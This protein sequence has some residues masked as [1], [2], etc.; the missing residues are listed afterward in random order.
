MNAERL[1]FG[2]VVAAVAIFL[3]V[4]VVTVPHDPSL[5]VVYI[6]Y[7]S[8]KGDNSY[9]DS[10]YRG[11]FAAQE[12]M[13]F[14][15][16][17]FT[18]L[19]PQQFPVLSGSAKP[20]LV[21]TVGY[22]YTNDTKRLAAENPEVRFLAVDQAGIGS[23]NV[24]SYEISSYGDSYLAGVLAASASR[25]HK[26]GIILGTRTPLLDAFRQGYLDGVHAA[27]PAATVDVAYVWDTAAGFSDPARAGQIAGGMYRNGTDV[28][29][30]VAG[31]SGTGAIT[32]AKTAPGRYIIGVDSDQTDLGPSVVLAS[33]VNRVDMVVQ[34]GIQEHLNGS[35]NGGN[36]V[37]G[38]NEGVTGLVFNPKFAAYNATVITW[39]EKAK[40][41]EARYLA[42]RMTTASV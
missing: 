25:T 4:L 31:L 41:A 33:A 12:A 7:S 23:T 22:P 39:E 15:K 36:T 40:D 14:S 1:I 34:A 20:G 24:R 42:A 13:P 30:T 11:L 29:Y 38:L 27:D 17:E 37:A 8:E 3:L 5:P 6:V 9:T 28:I 32:E 2:A 35:F 10:A 21:I 19:D 16:R 18:S 26:T